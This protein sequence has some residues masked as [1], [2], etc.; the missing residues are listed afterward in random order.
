MFRGSCK[1]KD[2]AEKYNTSALFV[3]QN[4]IHQLHAKLIY[5]SNNWAHESECILNCNEG[6]STITL[7]TKCLSPD[8]STDLEDCSPTPSCDENQEIVCKRPDCQETCS[9]K[10]ECFDMPYA[11][12]G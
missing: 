6:F 1:I 3:Y 7:S 9:G 4:F 12:K 10:P 5:F 8:W 2:G 11:S